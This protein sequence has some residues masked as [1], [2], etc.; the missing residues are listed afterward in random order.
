M[1][2]NIQDI[3]SKFRSLEQTEALALGGSRASGRNDEKSDYDL[4]VYVTDDIEE[5]TREEMLGRF[6]EVMEIGN[7]YW[8]YE[9]NIVLKDGVSV[10]I[11]YRRLE[12]LEKYVAYVVEE[13]NP[14]NGYTTCFWHNIRTCE[15][16]FDKTGRFT[17]LQEKCRCEYPQQL[18]KAIIERNMKLLHGVLPSYDKQITKAYDRHDYVS[19]N[20]RVSAF[21]ESYFDVI[22]ALNE[23]TRPGEKRLVQICKSECK[24]LP[25]KFE[26]NIVG[27]FEYMFKYDVS[28]IL[29]S[30]VDELNKV[31]D[32]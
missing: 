29:Q 10:D 3:Y 8:E 20:H 9:D 24:I 4:Y 26:Q 22:F 12:E 1:Q 25:A 13:C 32:I 14:M 17:K 16:I 23:M 30:M 15:I 2:I 21:L 11:I 31:I 18:K 19:I 5:S 27:L 28:D 6:C 7:H